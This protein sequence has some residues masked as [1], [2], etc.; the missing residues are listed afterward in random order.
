M[1][2]GAFPPGRRRRAGM[3]AAMVL[4]LKKSE[5]AGKTFWRGRGVTYS[6]IRK[7]SSFTHSTTTTSSHPLSGCEESRYGSQKPASSIRTT[8]TMMIATISYCAIATAIAVPIVAFCILAYRVAFPTVLSFPWRST[9]PPSEKNSRRR[10]EERR[11]TVVFAG[12][13]NPP[14]WGHLVMI[15]YLADR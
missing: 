11:T 10:K 2:S 13:F 4:V 1:G 8:K 15:R 7:V 3:L 12:S 9:L 14:H 5:S 6:R